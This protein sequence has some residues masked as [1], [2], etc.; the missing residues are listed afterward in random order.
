MSRNDR[1]LNLEE[2]GRGDASK[3]IESGTD[4]VLVPLG[5]LER[6]GNPFTP[7]GLDGI[8]VRTMVERA[9]RKAD[10]VHTPLMPFGWAPMHIGLAG[11]GCGAVTLRSETF[12]S[13]IEDVARSLVFQGFDKVVFATLHGPNVE[14]AEDVLYSLRYETGALV[15]LYGGRES[16]DVQEIFM[17][18]PARLTSD[19]EC[20]MA[21]ALVGPFESEEYLARSYD[22]HSPDWFGEAVSKISGMGSA[23]SFEGAP[24]I[25]VGLD[26][27][28]YTRKAVERPEPSQAAP[29][30]GEELLDSLSDH[31]AR[32]CE[33]L[34]GIEV[35]VHTRD[36]PERAR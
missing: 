7:L 2:L 13:V 19:M 34:K 8:I 29:E 23:L 24:N 26:D 32:F 25:H 12:R 15:A 27:S 14:V 31:L 4:T 22:I 18:P 33:H 6:H 21:M 1:P 10:V 28:E 35:E 16:S 11:E 17:S 20:S 5:S 9:A 3:R 36:W 30:R